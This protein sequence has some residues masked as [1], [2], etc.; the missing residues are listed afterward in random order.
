MINLINGDCI[1]EMTK[2]SSEGVKV[3]AIIVDPPYGST[4]LEWDSI[5]P[6]KKIWEVI[7]KLRYDTTPVLIFGQE[8]FSSHVRLSNLDEYKYDWYWQKERLTNVFQVKRRP[9][10]VIETISVFYKKQCYYDP[11]KTKHTGKLV[12]NKVGKN[13][14]FSKTLN[15]SK[16]RVKPNNYKD[17]RTRYPLQIIQVNRDNNTKNVHPTQKPV[18]LMKYFMKTYT[19]EGDVVL[20]FTMGSGTTGVACK[21]LN[22]DFIGIEVNRDYYESAQ[23]RISNT[24]SSIQS[25]V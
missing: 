21:Q 24:I 13:G 1:E 16:S 6:I 23:N 2:L 25:I 7:K 22:R 3:N 4:P 17:D 11:Q 14:S 5:L 19:K 18:D 10:K 9:G 20:D 12:N 15:G 8:P